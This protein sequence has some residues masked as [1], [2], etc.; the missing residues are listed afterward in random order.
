MS[1]WCV[2]NVSLHVSLY[3]EGPEPVRCFLC[4][5][6]LQKEGDG[7]VLLRSSGPTNA[8]NV[9]SA[10]FSSRIQRECEQTGGLFP[11]RACSFWSSPLYSSLVHNTMWER[12]EQRM[13]PMLSVEGEY[14]TR[15][16]PGVLVAGPCS[17][18]DCSLCF[19]W[20]CCG[21]QVQNNQLHDNCAFLLPDHKIPVK[22]PIK[23]RRLPVLDAP[24]STALLG[25]Y[26]APKCLFYCLMGKLSTTM[27]EL[28]ANDLRRCDMRYC[29]KV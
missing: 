4:T 11:V 25:I 3:L 22:P 14:Y 18:T 23:T 17:F 15:Q 5:I 1:S 26:M 28:M 29:G 6:W 7:R 8:S 2:L 12:T 19:V 13:K 10:E 20:A 21:R 16:E 24:H 9:S 27:A